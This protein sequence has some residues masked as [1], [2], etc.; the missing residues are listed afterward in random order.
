VH[1]RYYMTWKDC[2]VAIGVVSRP[3]PDAASLKSQH[4]GTQAHLG[5]KKRILLDVSPLAVFAGP[6]TMKREVGVSQTYLG[7][8]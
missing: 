5:F 3:T 1:K 4:P 2:K 7:D 6:S 8:T